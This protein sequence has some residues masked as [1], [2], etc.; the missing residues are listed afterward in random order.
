M[1]SSDNSSILSKHSPAITAEY[2]IGIEAHPGIFS[3]LSGFLRPLVTIASWK[4]DISIDLTRCCQICLAAQMAS[5]V[6]KSSNFSR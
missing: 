5:G 4:A 1:I 3:A 6:Y 2:P